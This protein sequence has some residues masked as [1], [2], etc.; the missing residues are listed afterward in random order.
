[1][2]NYVLSWLI[3]NGRAYALW[4]TSKE[5]SFLPHRFIFETKILIPA[6]RQAGS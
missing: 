1:M 6:C 3:A 4:R 2:Q 5:K